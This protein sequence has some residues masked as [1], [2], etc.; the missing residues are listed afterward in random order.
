[1]AGHKGALVWSVHA[2]GQ[3]AHSSYPKLGVNA[4]DILVLALAAVQGIKLASPDKFGESTTKLERM[5]GVVAL[6]VIPETANALLL[7]RLGGGTPEDAME[8]IHRTVLPVNERINVTF[9]HRFA[10]VE[11]DT[12]IDG[13]FDIPK[14]THLLPH[15]QTKSTPG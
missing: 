11:C 13:E 12:D 1:M 10:P 9:G 15:S 7:P 4:N 14:H 3:A 8:I 2:R 6:N 5:E